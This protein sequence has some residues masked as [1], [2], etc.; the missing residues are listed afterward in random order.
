MNKCHV[1]LLKLYLYKLPKCEFE[2]DAFYWKPRKEIPPDDE[3]SYTQNV[4]GHNVLD[5]ML[6]NMFVK[7]GLN[8]ECKSNHSLRATAG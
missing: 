2:Q 5:K 3:P 8:A 6:K 7:S 4:V 1:Y